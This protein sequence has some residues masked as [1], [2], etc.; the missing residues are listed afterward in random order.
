MQGRLRAD[1]KGAGRCGEGP[2][3][4]QEIAS[5]GGLA[6]GLLLEVRLVTAIV[7]TL[8]VLATLAL[9]FVA[10]YKLGPETI[11]FKA[12]FLKLFS[13]DLE[14]KLPERKPVPDKRTPKRLPKRR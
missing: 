12:S 5:L 14:I 6:T 3:T 9:I 13:L 11:S 4:H 7:I 1:R 8:A 10:A 2:W